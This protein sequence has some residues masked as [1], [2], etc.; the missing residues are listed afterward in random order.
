MVYFRAA[1]VRIPSSRFD[2]ELAS[3]AC[4]SLVSSFWP[5]RTDSKLRFRDAMFHH[6]FFCE[7]FLATANPLEQC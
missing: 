7:L 6:A 1:L 4:A 2:M 5:P 3:V